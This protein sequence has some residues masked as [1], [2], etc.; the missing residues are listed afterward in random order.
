MPLAFTQEVF[1]VKGLFTPSKGVIESDA[2]ISFCNLQF[3]TKTIESRY[4]SVSIYFLTVKYFN[5]E[6]NVR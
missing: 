6:F 5:V 1:L 2:F 3:K 4:L